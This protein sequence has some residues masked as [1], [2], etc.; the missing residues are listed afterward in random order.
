VVSREQKGSSGRVGKKSHPSSLATIS[1]PRRCNG[2]SIKKRQPA[3][4]GATETTTKRRGAN[5][6]MERGSGGKKGVTHEVSTG[7]RPRV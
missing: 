5:Q 6:A 4:K 2:N 1:G 7:C 3:L